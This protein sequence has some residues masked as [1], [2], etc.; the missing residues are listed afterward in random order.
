MS[1]RQ[2]K[3]S[4]VA[5]LISAAAEA[6]VINLDASIRSLVEP[7]SASVRHIGDE[8]AL[9]IVCCNEYGLVT[10]LSAD[11]NLAEIRRELGSLRQSLDQQRKA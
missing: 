2:L 8:V 5:Q 4:E 7:A 9:H 1:S 6:K 10:G 11:L 3:H